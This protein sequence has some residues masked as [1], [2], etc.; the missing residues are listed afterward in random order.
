MKKVFS[1]VLAFAFIL[2]ASVALFAC[3]SK[4]KTPTDAVVANKESLLSSYNYL[5]EHDH[6]AIFQD[7]G[8]S[9]DDVCTNSVKYKY[10]N[11][12]YFAQVAISSTEHVGYWWEV[13]KTTVKRYELKYSEGW[14]TVDVSAIAPEQAN[15]Y[16]ELVLL[17]TDDFPFELTFEEIIKSNNLTF[18]EKDGECKAV[19]TEDDDTM[20]IVFDGTK[21]LSIRVS[22][23]DSDIGEYVDTI[24]IGYVNLDM[25]NFDFNSKVDIDTH[26]ATLTTKLAE[27]KA[28]SWTATMNIWFDTSKQITH[29][30]NESTVTIESSVVASSVTEGD[31]TPVDPDENEGKETMNLDELIPAFNMNESYYFVKYNFRTGAL[32]LHW[33]TSEGRT[34]ITYNIENGKLTTIDRGSYQI[35]F[36]NLG[37]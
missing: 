20:T 21:I 1:K 16:K 36:S 30:A 15:A 25:T 14:R 35:T 26:V 34:Y 6:I 4:E 11:G 2:C 32:M 17:G 37:E 24:S 27:L 9:G 10:N 31:L 3:G 12:D 28:T 13:N 19:Y 8:E 18:S 5:V 29:N 23:N 33:Q 22:G 7:G